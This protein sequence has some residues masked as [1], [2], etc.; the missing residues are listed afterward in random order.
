MKNLK[1]ITLL[2]IITSCTVPT[3]FYSTESKPKKN[4]FRLRN[5][6]SKDFKAVEKNLE[7]NDLGTYPLLDSSC[8]ILVAE[9]KKEVIGVC[10]FEVLHSGSTEYGYID[11]LSVD[12]THQGKGRGSALLA[13]AIEILRTERG[14][15]T[16]QLASPQ[17]SVSFY[18]ERGFSFSDKATD[19]PIGRITFE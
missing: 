7:Q 10:A 16:I 19:Y 17:K 5:Y 6:K 12:K 2:T 11:S 8:T 15:K 9:E 18:E 1:K 13:T 4:S 14:V 3:Y